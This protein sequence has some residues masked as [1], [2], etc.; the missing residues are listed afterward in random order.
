MCDQKSCVDCESINCQNTLCTV[1]D[2]NCDKNCSKVKSEVIRSIH[3]CDDVVYD[4]NE[5][6]RT[7]IDFQFKIAKMQQEMNDC[8]NNLKTGVVNQKNLI[9]KLKKDW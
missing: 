3:L 9:K 5:I 7:S 2:V 6:Y 8:I 1:Y 4:M